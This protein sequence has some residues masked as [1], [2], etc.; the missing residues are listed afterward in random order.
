MKIV[1]YVDNVA[2]WITSTDVT[3]IPSVGDVILF[4]LVNYNQGRYVVTKKV[5]NYAD[6]NNICLEISLR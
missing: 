1:F 4:N 5:F 6:R 2:E 3:A